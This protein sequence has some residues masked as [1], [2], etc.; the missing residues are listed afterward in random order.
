M[1]TVMTSP[2]V[3][4]MAPVKLLTLLVDVSRIGAA[5]AGVGA[6]TRRIATANG[7]RRLRMTV[8]PS[9]IGS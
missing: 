6:N 2:I 9:E 7:E 4:G 8:T 5:F 3:A 1:V